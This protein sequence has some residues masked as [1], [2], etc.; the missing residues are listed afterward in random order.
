VTA[1]LGVADAVR[2]AAPP[3]TETINSNTAR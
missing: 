1:T 3:D 2:G